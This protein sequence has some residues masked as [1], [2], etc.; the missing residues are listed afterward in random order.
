MEATANFSDLVSGAVDVKQKR[1]EEAW[2]SAITCTLQGR[3]F[4]P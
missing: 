3:K 2:N 4:L 1:W